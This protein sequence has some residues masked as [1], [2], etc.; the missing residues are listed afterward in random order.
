MHLCQVFQAGP[1]TDGFLDAR[2]LD[3]V[4]APWLKGDCELTPDYG[5]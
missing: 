2:S 1:L 3:V 4:Q 5:H